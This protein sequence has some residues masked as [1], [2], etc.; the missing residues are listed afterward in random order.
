MPSRAWGFKSPLGHPTARRRY[1]ATQLG[2]HGVQHSRRGRST[3][4]AHH[5]ARL[6]R[7]G[8]RPGPPRGRASPGQHRDE[9]VHDGRGAY[10]EITSYISDEG[11]F[12]AVV[13]DE[14][15]VPDPYD[16]VPPGG[17]WGFWFEE[18]RRIWL[19]PIYQLDS[20]GRIAFYY[21]LVP[22]DDENAVV[23]VDENGDPAAG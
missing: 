11:T 17:R 1:H 4:H 2:H 16:L 19:S 22:D 13:P 7:R 5:H 8:R 12:Y 20:R 14:A 15:L 18:G 23:V 10:H 3:A 9:R 6:V 21:G